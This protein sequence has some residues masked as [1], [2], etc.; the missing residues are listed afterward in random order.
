MWWKLQLLGCLVITIK[1]AIYSAYGLTVSVAIAALVLIC[2]GEPAFYKSF[3]T[4]PTFFQV[5]FLGQVTL[6]VFGFGASVILGD[7]V[8]ATRYYVGM[9][10]A[11][12]SGYLLV[13]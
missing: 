12:I 1:N 10:L 6:T 5:W 2:I 7:G 4:A 13:T 11:L 8:L 3:R 9:A